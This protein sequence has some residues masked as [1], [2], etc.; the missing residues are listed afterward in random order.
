MASPL[1]WQP[2]PEILREQPNNGLE[3]LVF[4]PESHHVV[5]GAGGKTE[6][7]VYAEVLQAEGVPLYKRKGGGGTVLLGPGTIVVTV[8]TLVGQLFANQAYFRAINQAMMSVFRTWAALD[9]AQRGISD[10]A[11]DDRK[12]VGTSIFRRRHY[13]LYQA[14]ILVDLDVDLMARLLRPPPRQP[15][16]RR[17][18]DHRGFV[19]SL[20]E[21]GIHRPTAELIEDLHRLL[22][23]AI[24]PRLAEVDHGEPLKSPTVE[25]RPIAD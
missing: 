8:H 12:I 18:R 7:E 13:L 19:T 5:M 17:D 25:P 4:E 20:R 23:E 2:Y 16:Y 1:S 10:I 24:P 6:K 14:S 9:F 22:P 11:V 21:L 15:D 3:L